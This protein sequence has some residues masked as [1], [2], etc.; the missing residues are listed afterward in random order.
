MIGIR[1]HTPV[2]AADLKLMLLFTQPW[3]SLLQIQHILTVFM[4]RHFFWQI[5][6]FTQFGCCYMYDINIFSK[7]P[8]LNTLPGLHNNHFT[9]L[10]FLCVHKYTHVDLPFLFTLKYIC[11]GT[12][13]K[14]TT[15]CFEFSHT[16]VQSICMLNFNVVFTNR[17][18]SLMYWFLHDT[19]QV[20]SKRNLC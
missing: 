4:K 16:H 8:V 11:A 14:T 1:T 2:T 5:W 15:L 6:G 3:H 17:Y 13:L 12:R 7:F 10:L 18:P 20:F 9:K 19:L